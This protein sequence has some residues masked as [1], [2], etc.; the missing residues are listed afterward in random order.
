MFKALFGHNREKSRPWKDGE[1][2]TTAGV[3]NFFGSNGRSKK[4]SFAD[5]VVSYCAEHPNEVT[6]PSH[7]VA[8]LDFVWDG[9]RPASDTGE[10]RSSSSMMVPSDDRWSVA[11]RDPHRAPHCYVKAGPGSGKTYLAT[12][13]VRLYHHERYRNDSRGVLGVT[14]TP[15]AG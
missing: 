4:A 6:V 14:F 8:L 5:E 9:F 15:V 10:S 2:P 12:E 3:A 13:D 11:C 7:M 1:E